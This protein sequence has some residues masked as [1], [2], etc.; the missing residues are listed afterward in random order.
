MTSSGFVT[1]FST[2]LLA[3]MMSAIIASGFGYLFYRIGSRKRGYGALRYWKMLTL[4]GEICL[5]V[6][7]I[8]LAAFAGTIKIS[9]DHQNLDVLVQR[10]QLALGERFRL[11]MLNNCASPA[12]KS[13]LAPYSPAVA[14]RELCAL[15]RSH[16][17]VYA[18]EMN[19]NQAE[20]AL[21][22]F[23]AK[24]PGC[25]ENVFT[26]HSDCAETVEAAVQLADQIRTMETHKR[27]SRD[28]EFMAAL[29]AAPNA[30]GILLL[31]FFIATIG[32]AIKCA[33]AASEFLPSRK[34]GR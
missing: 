16:I 9:T 12:D 19:W 26:R 6:G 7:L 3:S 17:D 2:P 30:W 1:L 4:I 8:G 24:Y 25:I 31:A 15:S 21:R 10:S 29:L 22:D 20:S 14:K 23:P 5:A 11:A 18:A 32:V 33:H 13:A 27:A 34:S 28:D